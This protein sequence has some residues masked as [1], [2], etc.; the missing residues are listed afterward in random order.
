MGFWGLQ[1][2]GNWGLCAL[3]VR[4]EV[5]GVSTACGLRVASLWAEVAFVVAVQGW[6]LRLSRVLGRF[7]HGAC[8]L[9]GSIRPYSPTGWSVCKGILL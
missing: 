6:V 4:G 9:W 2:L 8:M 3:S 7:G 5:L 1:G